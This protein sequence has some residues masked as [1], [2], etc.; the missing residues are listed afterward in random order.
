MVDQAVFLA[1]G[2]MLNH[3]LGQMLSSV[4]TLEHFTPHIP[5]GRTS[6][7]DRDRHLA[8]CILLLF[9]QVKVL[10][11][12]THELLREA[13]ACTHPLVYLVELPSHPA[14]ITVVFEYFIES[15]ELFNR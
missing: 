6:S 9:L 4:E 13:V 7:C 1:A 14:Q 11:P 3:S 10:L 15:L 12:K 5:D 2:R 8:P